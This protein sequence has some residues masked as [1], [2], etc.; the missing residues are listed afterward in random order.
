MC[1]AKGTAPGFCWLPLYVMLRAPGADAACCCASVAVR[2]LVEVALNTV[3]ARCRR[4]AA[5]RVS[6]S[7]SRPPALLAVPCFRFVLLLPICQALFAN[8]CI[9]C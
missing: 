1:G 3:K 7:A 9:L 8:A 6:N 2:D 5:K 4:A